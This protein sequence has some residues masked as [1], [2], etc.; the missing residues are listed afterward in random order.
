M[1]IFVDKNNTFDIEIKYVFDKEGEIHVISEED[2]EYISKPEEEKKEV[3]EDY[4]S[5]LTTGI[6][7]N[8]VIDS[9]M[10]YSSDDIRTMK[11]TLR[12]LNFNDSSILLSTLN[13]NEGKVSTK[14]IF[15]YNNKRLSLIFKYGYAEDESGEKQKIDK[16]NLGTLSPALGNA[17]SLQMDQAT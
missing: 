15:D 16:G 13:S 10:S 3:Y 7:Y 11:L 8:E 14:D 9:I 12:K 1:G 6:P 4:D 17:I 5:L 2:V